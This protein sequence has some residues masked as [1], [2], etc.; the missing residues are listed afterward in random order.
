MLSQARIYS[1]HYSAQVTHSESVISQQQVHV[2]LV[3]ILQ[4]T[5]LFNNNTV[6]DIEGDIKI[7]QGNSV[8]PDRQE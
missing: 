7:L 6:T 2:E 5:R 1:C 4:T 8:S 3:M